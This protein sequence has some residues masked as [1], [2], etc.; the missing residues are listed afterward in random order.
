MDIIRKK[1]KPGYYLIKILVLFLFFS[2][3]N[4]STKLGVATF[5][6]EKYFEKNPQFS[7][8][9]SGFT[10]YDVQKN[11]YIAHVNGNKH[12]TPASN[13]K[14]F[15]LYT[16]L[17]ILQDSLPIIRYQLSGDT[18][19]FSGA[20]N[21]LNLNPYFSDNQH[22]RGFLE[23]AGKQL[24][25]IP[26]YPAPVKYGSGW[27]WDD[28]MDYYQLENT[29]L[30]I[31][32]NEIQAI[33]QDDSLIVKP[34]FFKDN[35]Q[36][37]PGD[38]DFV[39]VTPIPNQFIIHYSKDQILAIPIQ[40][41]DALTC[42][43]LSDT[44]SQSVVLQ[45]NTTD[46]FIWKTYKIPF[47][48][49]LLI[50]MMHESDNFIAEQLLLMSSMEISDTLDRSNAIRF[51]K[52]Q[53][54]DWLRDDVKWVDGSGLSRYNLFTPKS[55]TEV[56]LKIYQLKGL[57]WI[58]IVFPHGGTSGTIEAWYEPYVMAKTGTLSNN[59]CLS[60]FIKAK[61]GKI[62]IFSFMHN[63]YLESSRVYKQEMDKLLRLIYNK[64]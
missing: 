28:A 57:E 22:L 26:S 61:S 5:K 27:A 34:D 31:Y 51:I 60:G 16:V 52:H 21:P 54:K 37:Q 14:I 43:L 25:Y 40:F 20:G 48:D 2:A 4:T 17:S 45:Y 42:N 56:L 50:R 9:F 53:M 64:Y 19:Y 13:T 7:K 55:M 49:S 39:E 32:G 12:F 15:T 3:C 23:N 33:I 63:H 11:H 6:P 24:I 58:E 47:P 38:K 10:L 46:S 36:I 41:T 30:P 8:E 62:Y 44:L 35:F 1:I 59:H 29:S 18:L